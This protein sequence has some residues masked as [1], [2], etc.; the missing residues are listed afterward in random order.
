MME[1]VDDGIFEV[2]LGYVAK[3][4][5]DGDEM[6][7]GGSKIHFAEMC[8]RGRRRVLALLLK[9]LVLVFQGNLQPLFLPGEEQWN[10]PGPAEA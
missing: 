3:R 2:S 4:G 6:G 8:G 7:S 9:N 1:P 5:G 10:N